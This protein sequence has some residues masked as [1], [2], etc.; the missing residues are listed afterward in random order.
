MKDFVDCVHTYIHTY[1]LYV[2]AIR[3]GKKL[4]TSNFLDTV[5]VRTQHAKVQNTGT[6]RMIIPIM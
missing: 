4:N 2:H 6:V 1:M 5:Y 3:N